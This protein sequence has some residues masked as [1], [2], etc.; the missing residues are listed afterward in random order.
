MRERIEASF[1]NA[2]I[3]LK[4]ELLIEMLGDDLILRRVIGKL[5]ARR[6]LNRR[7]TLPTLDTTARYK[8][9]KRLNARRRDIRIGGQ[10]KGWIEVGG[11]PS[12]LAPTILKVMVDG[13]NP[14]RRNVRVRVEIE[15]PVEP[16]GDNSAPLRINE[17]V[18]IGGS[19]TYPV[20]ETFRSTLC[21]HQPSHSM[22]PA[23]SRLRVAPSHSS[24]NRVWQTSRQR[25]IA[26]SG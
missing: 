17:R 22:S 7:L 1:G 2:R 4:I 26:R 9:I 3:I 18:I 5:A 24:V 13:L 15:L 8:M 14:C 23:P 25:E 10:V 20:V 12:A 11:R 6:R 16:L 21:L 19:A